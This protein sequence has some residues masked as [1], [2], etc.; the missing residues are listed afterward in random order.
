MDLNTKFFHASTAC[1]RRYNSISCLKD[2]NSLLICGRDN[3]DSFLVEHFNSRFTPSHL[4]LDDNLF[5]LV[6]KVII[7]EENV[8]LCSI[9]DEK[10]FFFAITELDLNKAPDLDGMIALYCWDFN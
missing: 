5:D 3:I 10:E 8:G 4:I 6:E 9:P 1:R 2:S 7:E